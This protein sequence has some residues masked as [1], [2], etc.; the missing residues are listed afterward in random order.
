[1][2]GLGV[3]ALVVSTI[4]VDDFEVVDFT[5]PIA[6]TDDCVRNP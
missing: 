3:A 1:V 4:T 2:S 6:Q 5:A